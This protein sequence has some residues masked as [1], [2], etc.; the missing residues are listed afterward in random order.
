[1][2]FFIPIGLSIV[3]LGL[4]LAFFQHSDIWYSVFLVGGFLLFEGINIPKGFSVLHNNIG[5]L[6]TWI[7]FIAFG[8]MVELIG[9]YWLNL[10][11]YPTYTWLDYVIHV[12]I[13]GYPFTGFLGLELFC[14]T[15]VVLLP[16]SAVL[17]GFIIEYPN[18]FAY[19]WIY[20]GWLGGE[21]M[22]IPI[23]VLLLWNVLLATIFFK[24][25]FEVRKMTSA[26]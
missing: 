16:V 11:D 8:V 5:F 13:V 24:K 26:G 4:Y 6:R 20:H 22:G 19:E 23:F 2:K 17:L 12:L 1:M 15:P 18:T 10:W 14:F 21:F 9:N 3:I 7:L 25:P